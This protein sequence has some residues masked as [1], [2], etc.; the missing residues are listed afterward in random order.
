VQKLKIIRLEMVNDPYGPSGTFTIPDGW[1]V[2]HAANINFGME[3]TQPTAVQWFL[4]REVP[5]SGNHQQ[6]GTAGGRPRKAAA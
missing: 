6:S 1:E 5:E 2:V 3:N 4:V